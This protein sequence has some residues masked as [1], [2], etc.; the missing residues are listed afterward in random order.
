MQ[1]E[2]IVGI[3][4]GKVDIVNTTTLPGSSLNASAKVFTYQCVLYQAQGH[5]DVTANS[6][7]KAWQLD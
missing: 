6:R 1:R 3:A 5:E 2:R 7:V 4:T